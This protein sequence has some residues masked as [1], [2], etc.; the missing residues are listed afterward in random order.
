MAEFPSYPLVSA[1]LLRVTVRLI[2]GCGYI[3][4]LTCD[5]SAIGETGRTYTCTGCRSSHW[6]N[7][8]GEDNSDD[9]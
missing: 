6:F 8:T 7:V 4:E 2:C 9:G 3:T 5:A 1:A